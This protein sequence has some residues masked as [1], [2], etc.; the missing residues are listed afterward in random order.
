LRPRLVLLL[1]AAALLG[2]AAP[3]GAAG[4]SLTT[5][6]SGLEIGME[7]E[8]LLL[9][10]GPEAQ[11]AVTDWKALGVDVVRI[12]AQWGSIAPRRKPSGFRASDP[13]DPRYRWAQLDRAVAVTRAAGLRVMLTVTGP[14][15]VWT[16]RVP[17]RHNPRYLPNATEFG[18]FAHA[19]ATRYR[20]AVDRYLIWN[21]PNQPG[22][23]QPQSACVRRVCTPV[24]PH[25]Y[26]SLVRA[27]TPQIHAADPGSE[28]LLGELAPIG[29]PQTHPSAPMAPLPFLRAMGCVDRSYRP[30]RGGR[31]AGF[32]P[33]AADAFGYHPHP[34]KNAPDRPNRDRDEAQFADLSRLFGTLDKLTARKRILAPGN[35]FTVHLTEFGYQ[36]SPPDHAIG[37]TLEQQTRYLQQASYI[38]WRSGR[39]TSLSFYQWNDEPVLSRGPGT[40][41]YTGWQSGLRFVNGRPKP[42]LATF[43][44]PLVYDRTRHVLWGQVRPD[45]AP[46]VTLM[47]RGPGEAA[48]HDLQQVPLGPDGAFELPL[49]AQPGAAYM[50]RWTPPDPALPAR[51]SGVLDLNRTEATRL[52]ASAS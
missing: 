34:V 1:I 51:V 20:D 9:G 47:V 36:T 3:A 33:A 40:R 12:H 11:A 42:V 31:C 16:S 45:A 7:D 52:R 43:P 26:R 32:K 17:S 27:A 15:P 30:I 8:Q 46:A 39:V 25:T 49:T 13:Q 21:E 2:A 28:V 38:A 29:D 41:A 5:R 23:L 44:D 24:A 18:R 50:Y 19:V 4:D 35:R 14:G 22:W 37:I 10:G 6:A 48:F